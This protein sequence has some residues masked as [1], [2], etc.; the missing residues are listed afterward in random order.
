MSQK[1][2]LSDLRYNEARRAEILFVA[3]R[4][5]SKGLAALMVYQ[6]E[7]NFSEYPK[8]ITFE[9]LGIFKLKAYL[10]CPIPF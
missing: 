7:T 3:T 6:I 5:K 2:D 4:I 9:F 10:K 1:K 8:K